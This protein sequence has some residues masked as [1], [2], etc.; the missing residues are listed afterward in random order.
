MH[1]TKRWQI[2]PA[3]PAAGELAGRLKV[4]PLVAQMLLNRGISL[5]DDAQSFLRPSLKLL[6][7]PALI[8]GL[9]AAAQRIARAIADREKIVIYGDYDVD[10]ITATTILWHAITL[11]GGVVDTYIPHRIDEGYGLGAEAIGQII[12]Q[13]ARLIVSVDCGI[14]AIEQAKIARDR[15]VD[16]II[17]DHH[18]WHGNPPSLPECFGIVHP[19]LPAEVMYPNPHLCG[20]GVAFKL[21]WGI[22]QAVCGMSR[23]TESFRNFLI[24]ATALAALGTIADVVPLVGENRILAHFGLGGLKESKLTGIRALIAS[25]A[26]TGQKLDSY[27]VGF[28]LAPRLNA[29]GRLGH[30]ALAV[31]ML[32]TAGEARA[33]EIA[34]YLEEQNRARQGVEKE[35]LEQ[36]LAQVQANGWDGDDH[37]ALVLGAEGWHA[38]VIGIVAS[39]LVDRFC[40]PTVMVSLNNGHGQG[41]ARSIAGFHLAHALE[42]CGSHLL[43]YGGH[44]M[45]AGLK[46]ETSRFEEFRSAFRDFA[47]T[48]VTDEMLVPQL[49]LECIADIT[50]IT[51]ALVMDLR[52]LGPCGHG[53]PK[54]LLCMKGAR[55]GSAPRRVGKTGDHLQ[56]LIKQEEKTMRAIAFGCGDMIDRLGTGT[57]I[58]LAVEP[59]I[60]EFNGR[61][62]V[63]LLIKDIQFADGSRTDCP[64]P[65]SPIAD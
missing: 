27:H 19:R 16:L 11:L 56:I 2:S 9:P 22:G 17:T 21:A 41:S 34:I 63:E 1:R 39:R 51:E 35:I 43:S 46:L 31:E 3:D 37:R 38:G 10:G 55:V 42:A 33:N 49:R 8:P 52:R 26:L 48:A 44:E 47:R 64:A 6:A 62:N 32:T 18:E 45:A 14:T 59:S 57:L 4:S 58:D 30:A 24:E 61:S 23:V 29:C 25:A 7:D 65:S 54:P 12:D 36:A 40:K 60:N 13:G 28:L 50:Q 5:A 20:A 15:G 53:N